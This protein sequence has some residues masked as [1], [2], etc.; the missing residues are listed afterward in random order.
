MQAFDW[1]DW[2]QTTTPMH[3]RPSAAGT[4][5]TVTP[6]PAPALETHH[7]T[8]IY[9]NN[10]HNIGQ[11]I[12]TCQ[13]T[14]I[15]HAIFQEQHICSMTFTAGLHTLNT[16]TSQWL[17]DSPDFGLLGKQS[18]PKWKIP[19]PG[20]WWTTVQNLTQLALSL[21]EKSVTVQTHKITN[22]Q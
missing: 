10:N 5:D 2:D 14:S 9:T 22:K 6:D 12:H 21:P 18:S 17:A 15:C 3:Q 20:R 1:K 8:Q 19:C 7:S 11:Y 13:P 16:F 4:S